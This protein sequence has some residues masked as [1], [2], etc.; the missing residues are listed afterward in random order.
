MPQFP[1]HELLEEIGRGGMGVVYRARQ[2][3]L[4]REVALKVVLHAAFAGSDVQDR[5]RKEA[6]IIARLDHPNIVR[7]HGVGE[8][9]GLP[10]FTMEHCPGGSLARRLAGGPLAPA[11]AAGLVERLARAVQ[12]AHEQRVVHRDLKPANVLFA[13]DGTPK[14]ADFGLARR[15]DEA[16]QTASGAVLGTP[17]YMAPEQARGRGRKAGPAADVWALGAILYECFTGRPPFRA[18]DAL[19][20]LVAVASQRPVPPR[21][22]APHVSRALE[23]VCLR[24]LEKD[25]ARRFASAAELADALGACAQRPGSVVVIRAAQVRAL[26][27]RL[28]GRAA[29]SW[30]VGLVILAVGLGLAVARF[31]RPVPVDPP[32]AS[33]VLHAEVSQK[34]EGGSLPGLDPPVVEVRV[35][36]KPDRGN[37]LVLALRAR[38]ADE[39]DPRQRLGRVVVWL[40]DARLPLALEPDRNGVIASRVIIDRKNLPVGLTRITVHCYNAQGGRGQASIDLSQKAAGKL[41]RATEEKRKSDEEDDSP[42]R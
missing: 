40:G 33:L 27:R 9:E 16:G 15:T 26:L 4:D 23:A 6:E 34:T 11:E 24:C 3:E 36:Q 14:V 25:P 35:V 7:V 39:S 18:D 22:L 8:V 38:P 32:V 28:P 13:A 41:E 37:D 10:Y 2:T 5:I 20:T 31:H 30:L 19:D 17:S 21:Q 42:R 1:G 12:A 29:G